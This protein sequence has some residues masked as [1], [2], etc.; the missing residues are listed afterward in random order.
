MRTS[1][2][3]DLLAFFM[4]PIIDRY[5]PLYIYR[6]NSYFS[7]VMIYLNTLYDFYDCNIR[8]KKEDRY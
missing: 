2:L 4:G 3:K 6:L 1:N 5:T 7:K 8:I